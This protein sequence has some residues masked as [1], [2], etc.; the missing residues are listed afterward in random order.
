MKKNMILHW[1]YDYENDIL[2]FYSKKENNYEFSELL[3]KSVVI[4]YNKNKHPI[5]LEI[6]KASKFFEITKPNLKTIIGGEL[7]LCVARK[8]I[9]LDISLIILIHNKKTSLPFQ[10]II[11]GNVLNLATVETKLQFHQLD[12]FIIEIGNDYF[13]DN[14]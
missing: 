12:F 11:G 10:H 9:R 8:E 13:V 5:G 14:V 1:D 6:I 7:F 2:F 4:D 3:N